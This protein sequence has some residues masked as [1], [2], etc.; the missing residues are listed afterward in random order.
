M[1]VSLCFLTRLSEAKRKTGHT[2]PNPAQALWDLAHC[3]LLRL[4]KGTALTIKGRDGWSDTR[5]LSVV[6]CVCVLCVGWFAVRACVR[7]CVSMLCVCRVNASVCVCMCVCVHQLIG[8]SVGSI[9][10]GEVS[11][12]PQHASRTRAR[13]TLPLAHTLAHAHTHTH[14]HTRTQSHSH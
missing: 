7:L 8:D 4:K 1:S 6:C 13:L 2:L 14:S 12:G 10:A 3:K 11:P 9:D 5:A